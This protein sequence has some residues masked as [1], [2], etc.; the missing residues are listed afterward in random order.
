MKEVL[1][2]RLKNY[3]KRRELMKSKVKPNGKETPRYDYLAI[4]D[5]E[6]TCQAQSNAGFTHEI[7]EFPVVL[8]DTHQMN[9]VSICS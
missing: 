2:K 4:I 6:A 5:F 9:I 7:I 1:K 8:V 3:Y